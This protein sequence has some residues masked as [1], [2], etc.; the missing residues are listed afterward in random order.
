M[1]DIFGA[2]V[3]EIFDVNQEHIDKITQQI[4]K[5]RNPHK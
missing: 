2:D 5:L 3:V 4:D 1:H